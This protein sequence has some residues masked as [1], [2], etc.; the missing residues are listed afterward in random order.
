MPKVFVEK[1]C[2]AVIAEAKSHGVAVHSVFLT[3]GAI[4]FCRTVKAAGFEMPDFL[5]IYITRKGPAQARVSTDIFHDGLRR[6]IY[7]DLRNTPLFWPCILPILQT[8]KGVFTL[9]NDSKCLN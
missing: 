6:E 4:A 3:A 9:R 2:V 8:F 7:S 1:V 5:I